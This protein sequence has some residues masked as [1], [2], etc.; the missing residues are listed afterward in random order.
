MKVRIK[1]NNGQQKKEMESDVPLPPP[2]RIKQRNTFTS[3]AT[4]LPTFPFSILRRPHQSRPGNLSSHSSSD[5]PLF[6][7]DDLES[8]TM[9]NY[10]CSEKL[11][12]MKRKRRYRGTWWGQAFD[13]KRKKTEFK[14]KWKVD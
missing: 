12:E 11:A 7:S 3:T 14:E 1:S 13:A 5:P 8:A 9:E 4:Q 6:S 2:P 10:H